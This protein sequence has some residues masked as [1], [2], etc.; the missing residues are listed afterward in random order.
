MGSSKNIKY[1]INEIKK[2]FEKKDYK[3]LSK[4]YINIESPLYYI[5]NKHKDL[6]VQ[7][8]TYN[9]IKTR[10]NNCEICKKEARKKHT[11][12][13]YIR[14]GYVMLYIP[15]NHM[16]DSMGYVYE[17]RYEAEKMLGRKLLNTECVHHKDE[18]RSNN[19]HSNLMVFKTIADHTAFHKGSDIVMEGDVWVAINKNNN[20]NDICPICNKNKKQPNAFMCIECFKKEKSKN[21]PSKEKLKKIIY[22]YS[23]TEIGRMYKVTDNAVRKWCKKYG[24]PFRKRDIENNNISI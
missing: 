7:K 22:Q 5:C 12:S 17:H 4:E 14:N 18:N 1:D 3:L 9:L 11:I 23:F 2:D 13:S 24:L 10:K 15:T 20:N 8:T 19:R 21:I 6:G 16:A